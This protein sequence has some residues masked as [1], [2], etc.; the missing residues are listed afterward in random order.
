MSQSCPPMPTDQR[1]LASLPATSRKLREV[2][3]IGAASMHKWLTRL[4]DA[5]KIH[6]GRW[7]R[8]RGTFA[9]VYVLGNGKN[10]NRPKAWTKAQLQA[11]YV[12]SLKMSG[13]YEDYLAD[14]R[15]RG[16]RFR[17]RRGQKGY[18]SE[19]FDPLLTLFYRRIEPTHA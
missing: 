18:K 10:A 7:E 3:G 2:I 8:T 6:I 12:L 11:R 19:A 5:K 14:G 9:P 15:R 17:A 4:R 1:I 13:L 16:A